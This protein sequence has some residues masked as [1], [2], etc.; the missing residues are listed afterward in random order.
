MRR[1]LLAVSLIALAAPATAQDFIKL[2]PEQIGQV[3]CIARL[4]NDMAP[5]EG[6][7]SPEL[8]VEIAAAWKENAAY[9]TAHPGDKPPLGDGVPWQ[10]Y[11]DYANACAASPAIL[12][13]DE[14]DVPLVYAYEGAPEAGH[15]DILKLRLV[16]DPTIAESVWRIDNLAYATEG[17]LRTALKSAFMD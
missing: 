12:K 14:A 4:G 7:L 3:F 8:K 1:A 13:M 10:T 2:T 5:V 16:A 15:T 17:D 9:E 11:Q 6:L